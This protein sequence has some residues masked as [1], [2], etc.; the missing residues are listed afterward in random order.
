MA[1][2]SGLGMGRCYDTSRFLSSAPHGFKSHHLHFENAQASDHNDWKNLNNA[3]EGGEMGC[4]VQE[5]FD[6]SAVKISQWSCRR[7]VLGLGEAEACT[8][9]YAHCI[10]RSPIRVN[11]DEYLIAE[12][13]SSSVQGS[14]ADQ[15]FTLLAFHALSLSRSLFSQS[16]RF[17]SVE[18]ND[19]KDCKELKPMGRKIGSWDIVIGIEIDSWS[20]DTAPVRVTYSDSIFSEH[21][22]ITMFIF[23]WFMRSSTTFVTSSWFPEYRPVLV[24][25][26]NVTS[27]HSCMWT[28]RLS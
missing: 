1:P 25:T 6:G 26:C 12:T 15:S 20:Q 7:Q 9:S 18:P 22:E 27:I 19:R 5:R 13:A 28:T 24:R 4:L 10:S 14:V 3:E 21:R 16:L 11:A 2:S 17:E 8:T 23:V